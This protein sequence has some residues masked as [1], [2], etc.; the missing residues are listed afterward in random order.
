MQDEKPR[1]QQHEI[2]EPDKP[3]EKLHVHARLIAYLLLHDDRVNAV[4][5]SAERRHGVAEG[6]FRRRLVRECTLAAAVYGGCHVA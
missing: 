2:E 5:N 3:E 1:P 4:H 6:N